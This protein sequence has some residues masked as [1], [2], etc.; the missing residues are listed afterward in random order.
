MGSS[1]SK[2]ADTGAKFDKNV[3]EELK[4]D[5]PNK[6]KPMDEVYSYW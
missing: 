1:D 5:D 4:K 2:A 3:E 6:D